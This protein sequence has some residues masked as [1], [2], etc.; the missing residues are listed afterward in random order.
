MN[1]SNFY[2]VKNFGLK[3]GD[4]A[5]CKIFFEKPEQL[6]N[7]KNFRCLDSFYNSPVMTLE[8]A[9]KKFDALLD[10]GATFS[11]AK[12]N[13][14]FEE[15]KVCDIAVIYANSTREKLYIKRRIKFVFGGKTIC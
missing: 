1:K 12:S 10:S 5:N 2:D 15:E 3:D 11:L 9:K 14:P 8:V 7:T 13:V 6:L 4:A